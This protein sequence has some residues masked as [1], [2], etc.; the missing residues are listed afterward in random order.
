MK[1]TTGKLGEEIA[2]RYLLDKGYKIIAK[3]F[4]IRGGEIDLVAID[5]D[6]VVYIEVK[7]RTSRRFGLPEESI[8]KYKLKFIERSSQFFRLQNPG[9]PEPERIDVVAVEIRY[10]K[11]RVRHIKDVS[12]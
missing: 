3:N 4:R 7:A 10:G 5:N 12:Q 6:T 2:K 8:N 1:N 9:L 11:V